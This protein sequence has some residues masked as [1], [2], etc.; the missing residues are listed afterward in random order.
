MAVADPVKG[1]SRA[2]YLNSILKEAYF[3]NKFILDFTLRDCGISN[4]KEYPNF[5]N[6]YNNVEG[7]DYQD[8][9]DTT[10]QRESL[11]TGKS[12]KAIFSSK[13]YSLGIC[14]NFKGD[15]GDVYQFGKP[16][17][18][19]YYRLRDKQLVASFEYNTDG[20]SARIYQADFKYLSK[21][22]QISSIKVP[23]T[24]KEGSTP[25][26]ASGSELELKYNKTTKKMELNYLNGDPDTSILNYTSD[27]AFDYEPLYVVVE[28]YGYPNLS[29]LQ[30]E[31][32]F[33]NDD[34]VVGYKEL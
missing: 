9:I 13:N 20:G 17:R 2:I 28:L 7:S 18:V 34:K 19:K 24:A 8:N 33:W 10:K 11:I 5:K 6:D 1:Q 29:N 25:Y 21:T 4:I 31:A 23:Q 30:G 27:F 22:G 12:G 14:F 26:F 15:K 3:E 32:D 16:F